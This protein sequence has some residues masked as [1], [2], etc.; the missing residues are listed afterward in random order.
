MDEDRAP[1]EGNPGPGRLVEVIRRWSRRTA[2]AYMLTGLALV[3]WTVYLAITLPKR[4]VDTHYRGAWVGFD[5]LLVVAIV[6]TAYFAFR[7][8]DRVQLPAVATATL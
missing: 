7:V 3:P 8:D 4:Q 6:A 2:F 5:I 1:T